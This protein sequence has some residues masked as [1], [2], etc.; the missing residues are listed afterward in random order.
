MMG[1]WMI[2]YGW[3]DKRNLTLD[4]QMFFKNNLT[5]TGDII[6]SQFIG[7]LFYMLKKCNKRQSFY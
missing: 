4:D 2:V 3:T 6:G 5:S 7:N 1:L